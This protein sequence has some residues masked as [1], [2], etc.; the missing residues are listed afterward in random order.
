MTKTLSF[1]A[2]AILGSFERLQVFPNEN[3]RRKP[4]IGRVND[5]NWWPTNVPPKGLLRERLRIAAIR[6]LMR[7]EMPDCVG[8]LFIDSYLP[9]ISLG[10]LLGNSG[11]VLNPPRLLATGY[12]RGG[13]PARPI[14]MQLSYP[15]SY[16]RIIEKVWHADQVLSVINPTGRW[17][18]TY[19]NEE[20][21]YLIVE[22]SYVGG[23]PAIEAFAASEIGD[24]DQD[25]L[26]EFLDAWGN[27]IRWIRWPAGANT[28]APLNPD[29]LN[30]NGQPS[31]D[32]FDP[33]FADI[34]YDPANNGVASAAP[35]NGLRPMVV[36]A[37]QDGRFGIRFYAVDP[38]TYLARAN[39]SP[40][41]IML[42][43]SS[44]TPKSP[45]YWTA[46][47]FNWP[48][49]YSP[50]LNPTASNLP[51]PRRGAILDT[52]IDA[53]HDPIGVDLNVSPPVF[54]PNPDGDNRYLLHSQDNVTNLDE[55][56]AAP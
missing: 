22:E 10:N 42:N 12:Q 37:G 33:T 36:S 50:R 26:K 44:T 32:P 8:D 41:N 45:L 5:A 40:S 21:L 17:S 56:G 15:A 16:R 30:P 49:P 31:S 19:S 4:P 11:N 14:V 27:P 1:Q 53:V 9:T 25:G 3:L 47:A 35:G 46:G 38:S 20:L 29:P 54:F 43:S 52:S 7:L 18:D 39:F 51:N 2:D 23:A 28:V 48:D 24:L 34:G 13:S 55:S 6:D